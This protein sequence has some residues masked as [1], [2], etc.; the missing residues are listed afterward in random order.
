MIGNH[1]D[2][3]SKVRTW[4]NAKAECELLGAHLVVVND[5]AENDFLA[6]HLNT[7]Q[8]AWIGLFDPSERDEWTWVDGERLDDIGYT[9]W[10]DGEPN[11]WEHAPGFSEACVEMAK[12]KEGKWNDA[13]CNESKEYICEQDRLGK[14]SQCDLNN[15]WVEHSINGQ[16][17]CYHFRD[18]MAMPW[19]EAESDCKRRG[20]DLAVISSAA[21]NQ[22]IYGIVGSEARKTWI[23]LSNYNQLDNA[24]QWV[25][26]ESDYKKVSSYKN[27]LGKA[28]DRK[29]DQITCSYI[30]E[31]EA[32]VDQGKWK[33][34][35]KC[36]EM[37]PYVC[38][39]KPMGSCP[40]GWILYNK[41]CY[42]INS[43]RAV[44][45]TVA[46][47]ACQSVGASLLK[48]DYAEEQM[49]LKQTFFP[50][51]HNEGADRD[52]WIG[53]SDQ[54]QDGVFKWTDGERLSDSAYLNWADNQPN[55]RPGWDCGSIYA[56][57]PDLKW[58]TMSCFREQ[59]FICKIPSGTDLND[60]SHASYPGCK[61]GWLAF[62]DPPSG[63]GWGRC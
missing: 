17:G 51:A 40:A 15:G 30:G 24:L 39:A 27:W 3:H 33:T 4:H 5:Q 21:E 38:E 46:K 20:G 13:M 2:E 32:G 29:P 57:N 37:Q 12:D 11:H 41:N 28:P 44:T 31:G 23:G 59:G 52:I 22:V 43:S 1:V 9:Y 45:W 53:F 56:G 58:E 16:I 25:T 60:A 47:D 8:I 48:I 7:F 6:L 36:G 18:N 63:K 61:P 19:Y 54:D 62:K 14:L 10:Q 42:L 35:N 55:N 50:D 34:D 49:F 26:S